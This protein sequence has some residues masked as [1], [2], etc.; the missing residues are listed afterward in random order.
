V[1]LLLQDQNQDSDG[2]KEVLTNYVEGTSFNIYRQSME[3]EN[4]QVSLLFLA[5][6]IMQDVGIIS[7]HAFPEESNN[8]KDP[9]VKNYSINDLVLILTYLSL[10]LVKGKV[11]S[12]P[13]K[14]RQPVSKKPKRQHTVEE[15]EANEL[16]RDEA[17]GRMAGLDL[18]RTNYALILKKVMKDFESFYTRLSTN[19]E[20]MKNL[21]L[22][23]VEAFTIW[24]EESSKRKPKKKNIGIVVY[25]SDEEMEIRLKRIA[26][27]QRGEIVLG[28]EEGENGVKEDDNW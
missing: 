10:G 8:I 2:L 26:S 4:N 17:K 9:F 12:K 5:E 1:L 6:K 22:A 7:D 24:Q 23:R 28:D 16:I 14:V 21:T 15:I 3:Q 20:Y 18:I 27:I 19:P 13:T 11:L 25:D